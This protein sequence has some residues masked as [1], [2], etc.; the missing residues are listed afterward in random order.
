MALPVKDERRDLQAAYIAVVKERNQLS[1]TLTSFEVTNA[2]QHREIVEQA[3]EIKRLRR[4]LAA[5]ES[6]RD[7]LVERNRVLAQQAG[8]PY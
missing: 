1:R 5:A 8:E 3:A 4:E 2:S 6:Q 7:F